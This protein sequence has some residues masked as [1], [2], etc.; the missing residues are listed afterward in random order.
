MTNHPNRR[1]DDETMPPA[2][3]PNGS[4]AFQPD[5]AALIGHAVAKALGETLPPLL[6]E[7][8]GSVTRQHYC[9]TC[10][11]DRLNWEIAHEADL[12]AAVDEMNIAA[13]ALP[14]GDPRLAQFNPFMFLA[15]HLLP[16]QDPADP[17]PEAIPDPSL[18]STMSGGTLYCTAHVPGVNRPGETPK[19]PLLVATTTINPAAR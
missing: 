1:R 16:S 5:A 13:Q 11:A 4:H 8:L 19:R 15:P 9:A 17:H 6:A 7:A 3:T 10:L 2:Q 14:P 18:W 12:R